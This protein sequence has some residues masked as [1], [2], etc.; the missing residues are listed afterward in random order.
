MEPGIPGPKSR[1]SNLSEPQSSISISLTFLSIHRVRTMSAEDQ[2]VIASPKQENTDAMIFVGNLSYQTREAELH[3]LCEK[4]GK[5]YVILYPS[6]LKK[7][8]IRHKHF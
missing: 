2:T 5:V 7:Q 6:F 1:T 4:F 8:A 3:T